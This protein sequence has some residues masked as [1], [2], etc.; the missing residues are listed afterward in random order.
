VKLT[1]RQKEAD[2]NAR[3][4]RN[5][6]GRWKDASDQELQDM[7]Q[8]DWV[9]GSKR[10]MSVLMKEAAIQEFGLDGIPFSGRKFKFTPDEL[11]AARR[12][13]RKMQQETQK[14]LRRKGIKSMKIFRGVK[15]E[16]V[17]PGAVESWSTSKEIARSFGTHDV[18]VDVVPAK[19]ILHFRGSPGWIDGIF[20]NQSEVMVL[21]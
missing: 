4:L 12:V 7:F 15:S 14:E 19:K 9:H 17:V 20:G 1:P 10:R 21:N 5:N 6:P 2:Q 3:W 18:M 13:V 8:W 11:K 16:T